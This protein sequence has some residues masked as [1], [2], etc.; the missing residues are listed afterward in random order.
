MNNKLIR[1]RVLVE[2]QVRYKHT[3]KKKRI[4]LRNLQSTIVKLRPILIKSRI[5][6]STPLSDVEYSTIRV[7]DNIVCFCKNYKN[8]Y[9]DD[10]F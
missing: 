3:Q 5:N 4:D 2:W 10:E 6:N 9:Y 1:L 8:E 7:I